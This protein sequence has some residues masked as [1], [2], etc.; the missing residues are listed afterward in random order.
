VR[1]AIAGAI[2]LVGALWLWLLVRRR[3]RAKPRP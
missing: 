3:G 1:W 2:V